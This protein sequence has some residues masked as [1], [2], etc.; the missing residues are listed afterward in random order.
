MY[1]DDNC[2]WLVCRWDGGGYGNGKISFQA[3]G[4][5]GKDFCQNF[6]QPFLENI[7]RRSCN[8]ESWEL[9]PLFH[10]PHRKCQPFGSGS[11]LVVSVGTL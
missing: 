10:N 7:D 11:Y 8:D 5:M 6:L 1:G 4:E 2:Y 9:I 3:M